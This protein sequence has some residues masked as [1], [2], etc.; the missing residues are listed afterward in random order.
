MTFDSAAWAI[1]GPEIGA[2]LARRAL[3]AT[4]R[5]SGVVQKDDL[6]VSPLAVPGVGILVGEGTGIVLNGYQDDPSEAYVVNNPGT[7]TVQAAEMPGA[8]PSAQSYMVCV[9]VGDP[10]FDQSSHPW[11]VSPVP[12]GEETT[13][14]YVRVTLIPCAAGATTLGDTGYPYLALARLDIP[15][16]TT[17]VQ[18]SYIKELGIRK[19]AAPRQSQTMMVGNVWTSAD[20]DI[21]PSGAAYADWGAKYKPTVS[22]PSWA[23][24][25]IVVANINGVRLT[26]PSKNVTGGVR[27][28]LGA[29]TGPATNFD[30]PTSTS[31]AQRLNLQTAGEYDVSS[32]AGTDAILRVEG[33][34]NAPA[35]PTAAQKL[36]LQGGSQ[37]VFDVRFFEE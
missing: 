35:A 22:V 10:D 29:V 19:L 2:S 11:M 33:F 27:T 17:T 30:L 13:F 28:Q 34:E 1:N 4:S 7:H 16:N 23:K 9:V 18:A 26:D 20:T 25:A 37:I 5:Q 8:N 21:I 36:T 6:K 14:Q 3:Y 32:I 15:A 24:R 12:A 31:G